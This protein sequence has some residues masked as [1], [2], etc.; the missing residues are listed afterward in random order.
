MKW[1][2]NTLWFS[3]VFVSGLYGQTSYPML[4]TLQ[5]VAI[6]VGTT[7][8][9]EVKS[10]YSMWGASTVLI[11][12]EDLTAEIIH[13]DPPAAKEGESP[14]PPP[15]L[16]SLKIKFTAKPT[17]R[18]GVREFRLLTPRGVSTMGQ[19]VVTRDTVVFEDLKT[20]SPEEAQAF[21]LPA[22]LTG[23]IEKGEDRDYFKFQAL[24]G[25]RL[26][27]HCRC[28]RLQDR[29]HDLQTHADPIITIKNGQGST[30]AANDNYFAADPFMVVHIQEAGE[31][32]LEV[33]DVR[34]SGNAFWNYAI[35]V[36]DR[37][38]A[39]NVYPL[40][41]SPTEPTLF[42]LVGDSVREGKKIYYDPFPSRLA[43][44]P[45]R[46]S[47]ADQEKLLDPVSVYVSQET[48]LAETEADNQ[49]RDHA[50]EVAVPAVVNGRV[51]READIDYYQ[52]EAKKGETYSF[53]IMARRLHSELD[54]Y[55]V[56]EDEA[57]KQ[58]K[59]A[60]DFQFGRRTYWDSRIEHYAIPADGTYY[61][62][63]F[64]R[65]LRGGSAFVYALEISRS[66]PAFELLLDTDKTLTT[67]GTGSVV[68][69]RVKRQN[70]FE[71]EIQLHVEGMPE[72]VTAQAGRILSSGTD[73]CIIFQAAEEAPISARNVRIYGSAVVA[74]GKTLTVE[75]ASYQETY[76]PGGGRNHFPVKTHTVSVQAPSD[77]RKMTLSTNDITMRPGD[78]IKI[79]VEM[80]RAE[81]FDKN[82]SLDVL[83]QHLSSV[84]GN[85]LPKG[86]K[87]DGNKSKILITGKETKGHITLIADDTIESVEKQ[88]VSVM[89]N[90]SINFVM[91]AT[92]SSKPLWITTIPE[93]AN[94][95]K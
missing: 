39:T 10:R 34:F 40:A 38:Y 73:G 27:F 2:I 26:V 92:Y 80:V 89:A 68:F 75:A 21:E 7:A 16:T 59:T 44:G 33:R 46:L 28:M 41:I 20:D 37:P 82:I 58:L 63:V 72:G 43:Y 15:S 4:M 14:P 25:Q 45:Q 35:D 83:F 53:E 94:A 29:I 6:Q 93:A 67:P 22:T 69:C 56:I 19:I 9:L 65:H 5:P 24:A 18:P 11:S 81:G 60:D 86:I 66:Q 61:L 17:A 36:L 8:E 95:D 91:K 47:L 74:E 76:M 62:A 42:E 88:Q 71:G 50:Q 49:D 77:I 70:G 48:V 51:D 64:D 87:M 23:V 32:I 52:F 55:M 78:E 90:I 30:V 3:M 85:T 31:Y 1:I 54:S 13:P 57:G 12:G 84:W 79:D